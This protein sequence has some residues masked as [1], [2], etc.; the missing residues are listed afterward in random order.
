MLSLFQL[1]QL[2]IIY[3]HSSDA[4][5]DLGC[6]LHLHGCITLECILLVCR[7]HPLTAN[8]ALVKAT[9]DIHKCHMSFTMAQKHGSG[10]LQC[11][12]AGSTEDK[13]D[14]HSTAAMQAGSMQVICLKVLFGGIGPWLLTVC[15]GQTGDMQQVDTM[16]SAALMYCSWLFAY[17][18]SCT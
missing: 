1:F 10:E 7:L 5:V 11:T 13:H 3:T 12:V 2:P 17:C 18:A 4:D 6:C 9:S 15:P 16:T 14:A 8:A